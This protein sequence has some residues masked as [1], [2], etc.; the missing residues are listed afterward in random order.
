MKPDKQRILLSL[1][2]SLLLF[3]SCT[4][5]SGKQV[6]TED[7]EV[8]PADVVELREDQIKLAGITIG[9]VEQRSLSG[10]IKASGLLSVAP[11]DKATVSTPLAAWFNV[12]QSDRDKLSKKDKH[13]RSSKTWPSLTCNSRYLEAQNTYE[14]TKADYARQRDLFEK[15]VGAQK[16]LQQT[17]AAYKSASVTVKAL[18]QKLRVLGI[19]PSKLD[20]NTLRRTIPLV[21]PISGYVTSTQLS[22][23][24]SVDATDVLV[25]LV[26]NN[27][28]F[29]DLTLY[30][31]QAGT[32]KTVN[33]YTLSPTTNRTA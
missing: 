23:G 16:D 15:Q 3:I 26:N 25:E 28:L 11:E 31:Q 9:A 7:H 12:H 10:T 20:E 22:V 2:V 13:W 21:A 24:Q 29:L 32:L 18:E 5:K 19:D 6:E 27:R 17:T 30:D 33:G 8:L 4:G 1:S 14:V